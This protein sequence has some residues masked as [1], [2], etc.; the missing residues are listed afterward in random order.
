[1]SGESSLEGALRETEEELGLQLDSTSGRLLTSELRGNHHSD[2]WLFKSNADIDDLRYQADEV[3]DAKWV[4]RDTY[5]KMLQQNE[6][7]PTLRHFFD[8]LNFR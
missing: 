6:L 7:V 3:I 2:N 1:M 5:L 8:E 4:N